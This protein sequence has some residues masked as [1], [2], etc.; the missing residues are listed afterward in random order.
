MLQKINHFLDLKRNRYTVAKVTNQTIFDECVTVLQEVR[1]NE[2]NRG[3][4]ESVLESN[5]FNGEDIDFELFSCIDRKSGQ[6]IGCL[7]STKA[8]DIVHI[9]AA[10]KEYKLDI[11]NDDVISQIRI[12]TRLAVLQSHRKTPAA[13]VIMVEAFLDAL[14]QG[15]QAILMSCE[16]NLFNMYKSIGLRPV[17]QIHN[18]ASG[19]YRIPMIC[20]P[21]LAYFK[22]IK[23]PALPLIQKTIQWGEYSEIINW[24]EDLVKQSGGLLGRATLYQDGNTNGEEH[25]PLT[26][27]L[28]KAGLQSFLNNAMLIQCGSDDLLIAKEDG[29]KYLGFVRSGSLDVRIE[30][31]TIAKLSKGDVFGEISFI[32]N[33]LRSADIIAGDQGAEVVLCSVSILNKMKKESDKAILWKNLAKMVSRKLIVTNGTLMDVFKNLSK[34][35]E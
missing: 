14:Q 35:I 10:K 11:L 7:R 8:E 26:Y 4:S 3:A 31:K 33:E 18:S 17:G 2:L 34:E 6:V 19:G 30:E 27:G 20:I 28:S 9:D 13:L 25:L 5:S 12:F 16:P 1:K 32:L 29:G 23:N 24:Y 15:D 22:K 21:D